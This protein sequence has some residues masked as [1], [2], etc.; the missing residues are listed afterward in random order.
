MDQPT[1]SMKTLGEE[2]AAVIDL[3]EKSVDGD[4]HMGEAVESIEAERSVSGVAKRSSEV[5]H[6]EPPMQVY[7][8]PELGAPAFSVTTPPRR[9]IAYDEYEMD[10]GS[11]RIAYLR[12]VLPTQPVPVPPP[13]QYRM[14]TSGGD[15]HFNDEERRRVALKADAKRKELRAA[16]VLL[17]TIDFKKAL[18]EYL[19]QHGIQLEVDDY[20]VNRGEMMEKGLPYRCVVWWYQ[21]PNGGGRIDFDGGYQSDYRLALQAAA[22]AAITLKGIPLDDLLEKNSSNYGNSVIP[23]TTARLKDVLKEGGDEGKEIITFTEAQREVQ[24]GDELHKEYQYTAKVAGWGGEDTA[25]FTGG[26]HASAMDAKNDSCQ[27]VWSEIDAKERAKRE[28]EEAERMAKEREARMKEQLEKD[29]EIKERLAKEKERE[30]EARIKAAPGWMASHASYSEKRQLGQTGGGPDKRP[31]V[32]ASYEQQHQQQMPQGGSML[33]REPVQQQQQGTHRPYPSPAPPYQQRSYA[34]H[35]QQQQQ[36]QIS[37]R[38]PMHS[39]PQH[40]TP[41]AQPAVGASM[42]RAS[43]GSYGSSSPAPPASTAGGPWQQQ[44]GA[45]MMATATPAV[46]GA[47]QSRNPLPPQPYP[48]SSV[49]DMAAR[50]AQMSAAASY[51][52]QQTVKQQPGMASYATTA[53]TGGGTTQP[54]GRHAAVSSTSYA[55]QLPPAATALNAGQYMTGSQYSSGLTQQQQQYKSVQSSGGLGVYGGAASSSGPQTAM[56]MYTGIYGQQQQQARTPT[57]GPSAQPATAAA[58]AGG[59]QAPYAGQAVKATSSLEEYAAALATYQKQMAEYAAKCSAYY[60]Q[61]QQQQRQ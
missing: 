39:V 48:Q 61:Q 40:Q 43:F 36:Q 51:Y 31:R 11:S 54:F 21:Q 45:T 13:M 57:P 55:Q 4:V 19:Q 46:G 26:W 1:A 30:R 29:K 32:A 33:R 23:A 14:P 22:H 5:I 52:G 17:Y 16:S 50:A 2:P 42:N 15:A 6:N 35:N 18:E 7:L 59:G 38:P 58:A 28:E 9:P 3:S 24:D 34:H 60:A 10:N 49:A 37:N 44:Q 20:S 47:Y 53:A 12:S 25:E 8:P 56:P 41:T 27:K